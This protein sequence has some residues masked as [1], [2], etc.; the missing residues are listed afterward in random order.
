MA[1][2]QMFPNQKLRQAVD[3]FKKKYLDNSGIT[4]NDSHDDHSFSYSHHSSHPHHRR[5]FGEEEEE[6]VVVVVEEW[7]DDDVAYSGAILVIIINQRKSG[8][9][10]PRRC[11][12]SSLPEEPPISLAPL[13]RATISLFISL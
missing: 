2:D 7:G 3:G 5:N 1:L 6:E 9:V 13:P 10:S 12:I 4:D 11:L 8:S